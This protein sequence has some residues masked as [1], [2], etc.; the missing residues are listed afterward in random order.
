[1]KKR[2]LVLIAILF[3]V[4]GSMFAQ[5][6][7]DKNT[8]LNSFLKKMGNSYAEFIKING[9]PVKEFDIE[10]DSRRNVKFLMYPSMQVNI[11]TEDDLEY[12]NN[13]EIFDPSFEIAP[14]VSVGSNITEVENIIGKSYKKSGKT[15]SFGHY[16]YFITITTGYD[17]IVTSIYIQNGTYLV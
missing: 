9:K 6:S 13:I 4:C 15:Y 10:I 11:L 2:N 17:G 16:N 12:L 14:G 3:V 1:M 5:N 8:F 7:F